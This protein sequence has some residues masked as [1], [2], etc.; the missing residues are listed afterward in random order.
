MLA[1]AE[2]IKSGRIM[3]EVKMIRGVIEIIVWHLWGWVVDVTTWWCWSKVFLAKIFKIDLLREE[4]K[5]NPACLLA[6]YQ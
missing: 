4:I 5:Q 3:I 6:C 2:A 1:N